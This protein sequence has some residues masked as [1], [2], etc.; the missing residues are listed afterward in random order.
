MLEAEG[1]AG[2]VGLIANLLDW[3]VPLRGYLN[4]DRH[5]RQTTE[6]EKIVADG[7]G[8]KQKL[9][10][11][12]SNRGEVCVVVGITKENKIVPYG[13]WTKESWAS[14]SREIKNANHP[15]SRIKFTLIADLLVS[16]GKVPLVKY[17]GRLEEDTQCCIWHLPHDLLPLLK[18]KGE[19]SHRRSWAIGAS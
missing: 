10:A 19:A 16:D 17:M 15:S 7:T 18:Y 8:Y 11:D 6:L 1:M 9:D 3:I 5:S 2:I 12:G 13:A 4:I 14:I